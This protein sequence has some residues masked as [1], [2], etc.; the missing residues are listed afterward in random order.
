MRCEEA[1]ELINA[2]VDNELSYHERNYIDVHLKDCQRCRFIYEQELALKREVRRAGASMKAPA[3]LRK[4]ILSDRRIFGERVN[5]GEGWK[6]LFWPLKTLR[7]AFASVL[8]LLVVIPTLYLMWPTEKPI[9]V[10]ALQTHKK[11]VGGAFSITSPESAQEVKE[12]LFRSVGG[13]FAPMEYDLSVVGLRAIGG[14]VQEV[15]RRKVLVTVYEGKGIPL[16]C[17]TFLGTVE[18]A[19]AT[20]AIFFD[21]EKKSNFYTF[22]KGRINAVMQRVGERICI[23]VSEMPLQDLIALARLRA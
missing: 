18:D 6:R 19:P 2:L 17:Y 1:Q 9:A 5:V 22:S 21:P 4:R 13:T 11:I 8:F 10:A 23:L 7:P 20:A 14:L 3:D 12:L 15:G 16:T